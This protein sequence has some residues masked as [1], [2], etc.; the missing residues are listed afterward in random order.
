MASQ[1]QQQQKQHSITL[2]SETDWPG[3][4]AHA[5]A[6]LAALVP[7]DAVQWHTPA[8]S[9]ADLFAESD[10]PAA[11][12]HPAHAAINLIVP[13]SFVTLCET[14]I[15]HNDPARFGLLYRLLWRLVHEPTLRHDPLDA[16]RVEAHHMAQAVRRDLHKMKAFVRFRTLERDEGQPPLHVAWFEPDHYIV[17]AAAPFFMRRFTQ[18]EWAILTPERS[19]HWDGEHLQFGPGGN[20]R[21]APPP[22][23]GEALWLT[24]YAHIFNPARLKVAMMKKEMPVKYWHNLPEAELISGLTAAATERSGRMVDAEPTTPARRIAARP[25]PLVEETA[26]SATVQPL[27]DDP[28]E[29]L[30]MLKR[31]T[32]RC[33]ECPIGAHATQSVFGEGPVRASLMVVGEQPGDQ[34]DLRGHPFVGPAGQLFDRAIAQLGWPRDQLYVTNAVKHFKFELRGKRRIH[35]T[36]TQREAAACLHWLESEIAQVRPQALVALGATAARAL[37]GRPVAVTKERGQWH[38]DAHGRKVLVT[39]HPSALLRGDPAQHAEAYQAWLDDLALA[40][41]LMSATTGP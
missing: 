39:L 7:P 11:H 6:L 31:A 28:N 2:A 26:M 17:E 40:S 22:D 41:E 5:R 12:A 8:S 3:F 38:T 24:Y 35:K 15:L 19:V 21:D 32:D 9:A 27:P 37:L 18:M 29:A 30:A 14:V 4:R 13:S 1:Q 34:E 16:D 25:V 10:E 20:R 33:R 36:P 23:A